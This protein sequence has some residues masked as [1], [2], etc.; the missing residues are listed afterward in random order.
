MCRAEAGLSSVQGLVWGSM[1]V[2]GKGR[3]LSCAHS[4]SLEHPGFAAGV[5]DVTLDLPIRAVLGLCM[6]ACTH[7]H[8]CVYGM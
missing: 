4:W 2:S 5:G 6:Y 8:V 1:E 3:K 7:V